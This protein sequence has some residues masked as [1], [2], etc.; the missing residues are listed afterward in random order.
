M[1]AGQ[2]NDGKDLNV[3]YAYLDARPN[4]DGRAKRD[5]AFRY[6]FWPGDGQFPTFEVYLHALWDDPNH[7]FSDFRR[8]CKRC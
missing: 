2:G 1:L 5:K 8:I 4:E 6:G 7:I 3:L